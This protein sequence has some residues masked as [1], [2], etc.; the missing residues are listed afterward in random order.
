MPRPHRPPAI[1]SRSLQ[2]T[3]PDPTNDRTTPTTPITAVPPA[4]SALAHHLYRIGS[5]IGSEHDLQQIVQVVTDE[6]TALT[7]AQFGAFFYNVTDAKGESYRLYTISGVPREHFSKFP[8]PRNTP[9]FGPTF[10]GESV[11]R[12]ADI[13]KDPRYGQM[14]PHHGMPPGHLP[15][16]SFLSVPVISRSGTVLGG[17][18]FGHAKT[19]V[20]I[21]LHERLVIGIAGWAAVAMDNAA[22]I[23]D[24]KTEIDA[25]RRSEASLTLAMEAGTLGAWEW[26]IADG[27]VSWSPT[28]ERIHGLEPGNFPGTFE[29]YQLDIHPEDR[30]R[31]RATIG[32]SVRGGRTHHLEYRIIRP[33]GEVRWL[34]AHGLLLRDHAG[35]PERLLG[36]CSDITERKRA[37]DT[38][39]FLATASG[40]LASSLDY[41]DTLRAVVHLA[42]PALGD[43]CALD[44]LTGDGSLQRLATAHRDPEKVQF[45]R[46]LAERYPVAPDAPHGPRAVARTARSQH[47]SEIP[48]ELLV[49]VAR[50]DEHLRLLRTLGLTSYLAVPLIA[51]DETLG[52]L[53]IAAAESGR[54]FDASDLA[55]AE[56]LAGRAAIAI[57]NAR[58]YREVTEA[59]EHLEQQAAELEMQAEELE[60]A[61]EELHVSNLELQRANDALLA[62]TEELDRARITAEEANRAKSDFL[63]SMSHELRTPLNAIAGYAQLLEMGIRGPITE[64]QRLDLQRI[65]RSHTHLLALVNDVLNFAKLEAGRVHLFMSPVR[66]A[67]LL[68][69]IETLILP[70]LNAK[71]LTYEYRSGDGALAITTDRERVQQVVLNLLSNAI[72]Y[73][74]AGGQV[75]LDWSATTDEI[76]IRVSDTGRGIPADRLDVIFDPF[77]QVDRQSA[78][79]LEGVGLGLAISRDIAR[80]LGGDITAS[81]E[82]NRGS[83]FTFTLPRQISE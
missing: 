53:T 50:D 65:Q 42:V 73:T 72:K 55:L 27:H 45:V 59:R 25:R 21:E 29:A 15:V 36:I 1:A 83:V 51:R 64:E 54:R 70:Q 3:M 71:A 81:S 6:A 63:A 79:A 23:R 9:V 10:R 28:L 33:D 24:L 41:E 48:D 5:I 43:W 31:V 20:F 16:R 4:E 17:L 49:S 18:F 2:Q 67:E 62:R 13:T 30:E 80:A 8:Q 47:V 75:V 14:A 22:L 52:V 77:V 26:S 7:G 32:A 44:I 12:S 66:I 35:K 68:A 34:E 60:Q 56:D 19:G 37:A 11:V 82:I 74:D 40:L 46:E 57:D 38:E 58:L 69:G 39:H 61:Q 78:G 76:R